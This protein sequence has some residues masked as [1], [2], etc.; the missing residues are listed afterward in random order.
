M[1]HTVDTRPAALS[2]NELTTDYWNSFT[3]ISL[4]KISR[5]SK[6]QN[7]RNKTE[8]LALLKKRNK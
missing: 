4:F 8:A 2:M 1:N 7:P 3:N 6:Y 5:N